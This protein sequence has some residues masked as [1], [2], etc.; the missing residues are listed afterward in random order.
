MNIFF[1]FLL[2]VCVLGIAN[3]MTNC[4]LKSIQTIV[5]KKILFKSQKLMSKKNPLF[6]GLIYY[7]FFM[8]ILF[9]ATLIPS[10]LLNSDQFFSCLGD[11]VIIS[12]YLIY[13]LTVLGSFVNEFT[14]KVKVTTKIKFFKFLSFVS[15]IMAIFFLLFVQFIN[16]F[17][18][19]V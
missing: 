2:F 8:T 7:I 14:K 15:A 19:H 18:Y 17:I 12:F 4:S 3:S 5:N 10:L 13:G 1:P 6:G 11:S 16:I 9:I